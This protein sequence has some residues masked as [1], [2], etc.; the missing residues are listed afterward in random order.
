MIK[1]Y[2]TH[3]LISVM[4]SKLWFLW[5][6]TPLVL[7]W[8]IPLNICCVGVTCYICFTGHLSS[9]IKKWSKSQPSLH[10]CPHLSVP[11]ETWKKSCGLWSLSQRW[12]VIAV[13]SGVRCLASGFDDISWEA[14]NRSGS[15]PEG[16]GLWPLAPW[17]ISLGRSSLH[18]PW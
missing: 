13:E 16:S 12:G 6:I 11:S 8:V 14:L 3:N 9:F 1:N 2:S 10:S 15:Q 5:F 7:V 17:V 4:Q 18:L